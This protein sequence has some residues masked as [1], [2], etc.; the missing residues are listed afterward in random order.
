MAFGTWDKEKE[1]GSCIHARFS[2]LLIVALMNSNVK[3]DPPEIVNSDIYVV[4]DQ[5]FG[6]LIGLE[7]GSRTLL[8]QVS[9]MMGM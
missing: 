7:G 1:S 4:Y 8:V 9:Y 2:Y 5:R 6:T 3:G